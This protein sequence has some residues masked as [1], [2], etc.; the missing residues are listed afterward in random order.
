MACDIIKR[1]GNAARGRA[2]TGYSIGKILTDRSDQKQQQQQQAQPAARPEGDAAA[3]AAGAKPGMLAE[4]V[5]AHL[6]RHLKAV[7]AE[8]ANQPV[9]DRFAQLLDD[10]E[11]KHRASDTVKSAPEA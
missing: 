1:H 2:S 3:A 8:I 11:R 6:G 7:Y 5:Q 9:P 4:N 10:L